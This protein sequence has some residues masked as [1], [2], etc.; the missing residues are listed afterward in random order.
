MFIVII[1]HANENEGDSNLIIKDDIECA[2]KQEN[3]YLLRYAE[4]LKF[5]VIDT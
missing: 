2:P 5:N 4:N 1:L 3:R